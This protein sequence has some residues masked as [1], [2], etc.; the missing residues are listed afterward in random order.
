MLPG[1]MW[2]VPERLKQPS[3]ARGCAIKIRYPKLYVMELPIR[4]GTS[5]ADL[6]ADVSPY[7]RGMDLIALV[8]P[9]R[10]DRG[11]HPVGEDRPQAA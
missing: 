3:Q 10:R 6:T 8:D 9:R 5:L 4:H 1:L 2:R 7:R 11:L